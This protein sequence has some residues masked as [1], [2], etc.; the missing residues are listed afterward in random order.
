MRKVLI[1]II[2]GYQY[3]ISPVLGPHCRFH[4]TCSCYALTALERHGLLRGGWMAMRRIGRCH[5]WHP[6]GVDPVPEN[7]NT[8]IPIP[9]TDDNIRQH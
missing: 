3:L 4:P 7:I 2:K 5:P 9:S 6:G 8:K 1:L